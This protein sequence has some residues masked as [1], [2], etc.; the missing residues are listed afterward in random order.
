MVWQ[1]KIDKLAE[2]M[3]K[4]DVDF[5]IIGADTD[6]EY[7][8]GINSWEGERFKGLVVHSS[9]QHFY[10]SPELYYEETREA[11]AK[12][13]IYQWGDGEGF[14]KA[15][16]NADK[17]YDLKNKVIAV[18]Q[19]VTAVEMLAL[20]EELNSKFISGQ[21]LV[22]QIRM[23]KDEKE[24]EYLKKAGKIADKAAAAVVEFIK[25]GITEK[26]I[27]EKIKELLL[28]YG[29]ESLS[30]ETIVA[31][32]PNSSKPHYNSDKRVIKKQDLIVLDFGCKYKGYCS[33]M[34][35][36]VFLGEPTEEMK[37]VYEIVLKANKKA[38]EIANAGSTAEEVDLAARNIIEEA[39]YG[40]NF[41]NRTGHGIGRAVHEGPFI[42][43][44][45]KLKLKNGM[46]FS[47][48]PGIYIPG[49]FGMRVEDI[50]LIENGKGQP[51]NNYNKE[52]LVINYS[53]ERY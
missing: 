20:K 28:E 18:N 14:L 33:D 19:A 8:A 34:S 12:E 44:G 15:F 24:R 32:G 39:G 10:I 23:I 47:I 7:F 46:A 42:K 37:K 38:E 36:T 52:M 1:N 53:E 2:L 3:K 43:K 25:P 5:L 31:S 40:Q 49:K 17:K 30:F 48:E 9:G 45:N 16:K 35:R 51:L 50:I 4:N 29:G 27:K 41:I 22:S 21:D 11:L 26:D 6:L 13:D